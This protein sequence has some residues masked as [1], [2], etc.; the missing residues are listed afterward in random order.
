[1][2]LLFLIG[3]CTV[4]W[5]GTASA[6]RVFDDWPVR[7]GA[8]PDALLR[9]VEAVYW[10]PSAITTHTYR[11]GVFV[12]DQRTP[13]GVGVGGFAAAGAWRL[14]ARTTIAAGYQHFG[15][16]DI[17]ET[18]ESPLPD[19]GISPTFSI[20][21]DQLHFGAAHALSEGLSAGAG[22]RYD[23]SNESGIHEATTS[24]VTGFVFTPALAT[25]ARFQ[26]SL[27]A[28]LLARG[29]GIRWSGGVDFA[30]P[31]LADLTARL[32]YG[33]RGGDGMPGLEHRIGLTGTWRQLLTAS[34]GAMSASAGEGRSW[35]TT[36]G[37][38]LRVNRYELGV[39]RESLSN[40]FGA[41]YSFRLRF[42][43]D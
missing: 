3:L 35:E 7:T 33:A 43:I 39:L 8:G 38:G 22:F 13:D 42:G 25:L 1:M 30:L 26:P 17:G 9:G 21:E 28:T 19:E 12:A 23:R 16:D 20:A 36:F 34:V 31:A 15:I 6:Q 32:G 2:R 27:G 4:S 37:A 24:L 41:A 14:D 10:N 18:S 29:G 5:T 11:G 40:D